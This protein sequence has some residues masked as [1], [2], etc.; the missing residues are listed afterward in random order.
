MI[1]D[2]HE[3]VFSNISLVELNLT[4]AE[5]LIDKERTRLGVK[6]KRIS[7]RELGF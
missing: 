7:F 3:R 6:N 1:Q 2:I 5:K 4:E